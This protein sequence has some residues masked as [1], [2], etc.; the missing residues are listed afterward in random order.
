MSEER[1][2]FAP[3]EE[4]AARLTAYLLDELSEAE[5]REIESELPDDCGGLSREMEQIRVALASRHP[6]DSPLKPSNALRA[7][8]ESKLAG[9]ATVFELADRGKTVGS[10]RRQVLVVAASLTLVLGA[11]VLSGLVSD[12]VSQSL[13]RKS[14]IAELRRVNAALRTEIEKQDDRM[15]IEQAA[16]R[17]ALAQLESRQAKLAEQLVTEDAKPDSSEL[18]RIV[19]AEELG[20]LS[21]H[22][23]DLR[24]EIRVAQQDH[25]AKF[26][27]AFAASEA[28]AASPSGTVALQPASGSNVRVESLSTNAASSP[29]AIEGYVSG[30]VPA[31]GYV[32]SDHVQPYYAPMPA[33]RFTAEAEVVRGGRSLG[34]SAV[35]APNLIAAG[36]GARGAG[37]AVTNYGRFAGQQI[38]VPRSPQVRRQELVVGESLV[39]TLAD[40]AKSSLRARAPITDLAALVPGEQYS[41]IVENRFALVTDTPLSTFSIDVDT[42][43]YAN[44]RRF[45][46]QNQLP[47]SD[48]IRIE[49]FINYF[50]YDYPDPKEGEPFSVN[51]EVAECPWQAEHRLVRIGLK[52]K[53]LPMEERP[54]SNVVFLL[55]VSG[56]MKNA[57]KLPLMK[58]AMKMLTDQL[59]ESDSVSIVTYAGNA[60]LALDTTNGE[61][62]QAIHDA[63]YALNANGSTNGSAGIQLAYEKATEAFIKDGANRVIL[64]TDGDLNVGITDDNALVKLITEKAASGV[65]LTVLGFG[66]GNLKDGKLEKLADNGNGVYAYIDSLRE[67]RKVLVEQVTGSLITIAKDVKIK[68]EFNPAE[69]AAYRLLGYENRLLAAPDFD[70]DAKDAGEIGAGHTVTALYEVVPAEIREQF[71]STTRTLKYQRAAAPSESPNELTAAA[72]SG[73]LLTLSLRYKLPDAEESTLSEFAVE[74]K[75]KAFDDA[76]SDFRFAASVASF[77]MVLRNSEFQGNSS[78]AAVEEIASSA[79]GSDPQ[80]HRTEFLDL[81]RKATT[82]Q[83]QRR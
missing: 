45:L 55:D 42:A 37:T 22:V 75:A 36:P 74:N 64:A 41:Q 66:E 24:A 4:Q 67:A 50:D 72:E 34:T 14:Q 52:G 47:P 35:P 38:V 12:G 79:I 15:S 56:S 13:S 27:N 57:N 53:E 48:A 51:I 76:S 82:L 49:E 11:V 39:E 19:L 62:K 25:D 59:N 10:R 61:S 69:V 32:L 26:L 23:D 2:P 18:R 29:M 83:P 77:G 31:D 78:L 73:E 58:Q 30:A 68:V 44:A 46:T 63:I 65:F 80:G 6:D 16:R 8:I 28:M 71:T 7:A 43:S 70:N 21:K 1:E 3:Q 33:P 9:E 17:Y 81:V 40:E 5:R 20:T 54:A 60:G